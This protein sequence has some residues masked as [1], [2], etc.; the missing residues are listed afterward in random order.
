MKGCFDITSAEHG[1]AMMLMIS[2]RFYYDLSK[3]PTRRFDDY[4]M[5]K[6]TELRGKT[7]GIIGLGGMGKSLATL[8]QCMGMKVVGLARNP[9]KNYSGIDQVFKTGQLKDLLKVSDFVA[10][11]VPV[12]DDTSGMIKTDELW[13]MKST[14]YLIDVSGREELYDFPSLQNALGEGWIGGA[15]IQFGIPPPTNSP[16]WRFDNFHCS[17]H[18]TTSQ[19]QYERYLDRIC[20]NLTRLI[21]G[22]PLLGEV[23]KLK[24]Y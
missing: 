23:D 18:R 7:L 1:L 9:Q 15:Y 2:R 3:R 10:L 24:G 13:A 16:F 17:Y 22:Q 4:Q 14:A 12:T 21:N 20:E 5:D 8:A 6:Q 19:E 11:C